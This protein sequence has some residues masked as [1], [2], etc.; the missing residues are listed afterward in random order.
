MAALKTAVVLVESLSPEKWRETPRNITHAAFA[1][2]RKNKGPLLL[3][4]LRA[5]ARARALYAQNLANSYS[6]TFESKCNTFELNS[7]T[8][9]SILHVESGPKPSPTPFLCPN[10]RPPKLRFCAGF[11]IEIRDLKI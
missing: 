2:Q 8:F 11:V 10:T 3:F 4:L 6:N 9:E 7:H 1:R 5:C